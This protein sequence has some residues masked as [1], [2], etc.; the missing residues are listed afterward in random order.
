M[1]FG[2][3]SGLGRA[4]GTMRLGVSSS[5]VLD[6]VIFLVCT[7]GSGEAY[8]GRVSFWGAFTLMTLA[9]GALLIFYGLAARNRG[10][11]D[12]PPSPISPAGS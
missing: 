1:A 9:T 10:S 8:R 2:I 3:R 7:D 12:R 11:A 5:M 4:L 6:E